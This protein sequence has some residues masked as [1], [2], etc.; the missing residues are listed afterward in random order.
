MKGR[1][2]LALGLAAG[3]VLL[4]LAALTSRPMQAAPICNRY[5]V[6][7]TGT[8]SGT[9][10]SSNSPCRTVQYALRQAASGERICVADD[11]MF[12]GPSVYTGTNI[13]TRSLTLDGGWS[14]TC[15]GPPLTC[16][17]TPIC[18]PQNV[19]L[20]GQGNGRVISITGSITPTIQC[21]TIIGGDANGLRGDLDGYDAGGGIYS[22]DAAPIIVN[23]IISGNYGCNVCSSTYGRGGGIYLLNAPATAVISGNVIDGNAGAGTFLG[24]GGG[25]ALRNSSAQVL[26]N[27]IQ[28]NLGGTV[29]DGGG[30]Y[31]I[32]GSP[33]IADNRILTNVAAGTGMLGNGA[34]V[35]ISS[36][37]TTT[38]ERNLFQANVGIKANGYITMPS[39]GGGLFYQGPNA[40]IR[41]N[42]F[43]F[44]AATWDQAGMGGGMYLHNLST[45][46]VVS[47]NVVADDNRASYS[48]YGEGGGIYLDEC[49]ATLTNNRISGNTAASSTEG[50]GGGVY[51]KGGGGLLQS[52]TITGN[53]AMLGATGGNGWGGG[54]AITNSVVIVQDNRIERNEAASAPGSQG[55]GGGVLIYYGAPRISGNRILSNTTGGGNA[56]LGGGLYLQEARPWLEG[57]TVL[58]NQAA[59]SAL[60]RGGGVRIAQCPA[61]TLTNNIV[62]RNAVSTT[63]SGV[64]IIQSTGRLDNNTIADNRT[65]DGTGVLVQTSGQVTLTNNIIA[66]QTVG[67][68]C[69]SGTTVTAGYTLFDGNGSNCAA[70][71]SSANEVAGPAALR[72]DYHLANWSN[73]IDHATPLAWVTTDVDGEPRPFGAGPDVGADEASC[74]RFVLNTD[75]GD[76]GNDCSDETHPCRTVQRA[77]AQAADGDV[78]CV[79]DNPLQPGPSVYTGTHT[80]N[81]SLTLD[82]AWQAACI[83]PPN[84]TCGFWAVPCNPAGVVLDA[85][86]AGPVVN[87]NPP[88]G[89]ITPTVRC[90]TLT[91]GHAS[92]GG[93]IYVSSASATIASNVITGNVADSY[94]GGINV[95]SASAVIT[96]NAVLSNSAG[97]G[98]GGIELT[99]ATATLGNNR[100]AENHAS[101]GGGLELDHASLTATANLVIR[102]QSNSA[103]MISGSGDYRLTAVNNVV[104]NNSGAAIR[105]YNYQ[106]T[107]MHNTIV[108]NTDNAVEGYYTA[109]LTLTNNLIAYNAGAGV[110]TSTGGKATA[111]YNLFWHNGSDPITGTHAVIADPLLAADGYHLGPGSPAIGAGIDAG[112]TTDIDGESRVGAP[113]IGADEFIQRVYLP[114][115]LRN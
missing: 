27:T 59:G 32:D 41:S 105:I 74:G 110:I 9:C 78:I 70:G 100:V 58:G 46:A 36:S 85:Q 22:K 56:G 48:I 39:R 90:L 31:V 94:G 87:I 115:V 19:V 33:T 15:G 34:G 96:A 11:A 13:I 91:G 43:R 67:I 63:G 93:G 55:V 2:V 114:L 106:A 77:L 103:W 44:N 25:I 113:D 112:V 57:N 12:A 102:N 101:Y 64:A 29:G 65:G 54:I 10:S 72:A 97:F 47:G 79:A 80:I 23:N 71:V 21:F 84:V 73:A 26:S 16:N 28:R 4:V 42:T 14:A 81:K 62:A 40:L 24:W 92:S 98:G 108:S 20:D 3:L 109:T 1:L 75:G 69:T 30:I 99:N 89:W 60:G 37:L 95:G 51:V 17:F 68:S 50:W 104:A 53:L 66:N 76:S 8:D 35:F 5:V 88:S 6:S 7:P 86:G 18:V 83:G 38:V 52:N 107:L 61:F 111:S 45:S 49:W 82:G